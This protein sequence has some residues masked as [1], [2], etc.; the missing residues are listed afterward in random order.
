MCGKKAIE[1]FFDLGIRSYCKNLEIPISCILNFQGTAL[2][3]N[4][5]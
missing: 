5:G 3:M 2:K 1:D 4:L